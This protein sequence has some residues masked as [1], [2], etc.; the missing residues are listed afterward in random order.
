[1]PF[2]DG[3]YSKPKPKP[4]S[5][6]SPPPSRPSATSSKNNG[7]ALTFLYLLLAVAV[8]VLLISNLPKSSADK[9]KVETKPAENSI[10]EKKDVLP[11]E[12]E[13]PSQSVK[14]T[15]PAAPPPSK[16]KPTR[17]ETKTETQ[18][19]KEAETIRI[20]N[21][22]GTKGLAAQIKGEI[23]KAGLTVRAIGNA[24]NKY[25]ETI[26]YYD[27]GKEEL[28]K[29][30]SEA[31]SSRKSILKQSPIAKPDDVLVVAGEK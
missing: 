20:L 28:A 30:V 5:Q 2:L 3:L 12:P 24:R 21:G 27:E 8:I 7:G 25:K 13:P 26:I 17:T 23:E 9:E 11:E 1:M 10:K 14:M 31:L 16:T 22:T 29:K 18:T 6:P 15:E 4:R 19:Q